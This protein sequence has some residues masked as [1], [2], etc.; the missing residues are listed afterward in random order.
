MNPPPSIAL[1]KSLA[2]RS[3][4]LKPSFYERIVMQ[5]LEQ[6]T[7]GCLRLEL[8]DGTRKTIGQ[9]DA[10]IQANVRIL[11]QKFF[12]LCVLFGD[13]GFGEAYVDGEWDTD[14]ITQ[15]SAWFILNVG[16]S[17]AMSGGTGRKFF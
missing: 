12:K 5:S 17:P 4:A 15:V 14:D 6:M 3:S 8:P 16:N 2:E 13:V 9:P 11:R 7:L 1:G 10:E